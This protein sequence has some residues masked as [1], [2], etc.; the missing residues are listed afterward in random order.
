MIKAVIFDLDDTLY[1]ER[2]FFYGGFYVVSLDL[3]ARGIGSSEE[4]FKTLKYIYLYEGRDKVF[5]KAAIY[6]GFSEELVP[7]LVNVFRTHEPKISLYSDAIELLDYLNSNNYKSGCITDGFSYV[8]RTKISAL[9]LEKLINTII[10]CDDWGRHFWKPNPEPFRLCCKLLGIH[11]TE[12]IF[13]GDNP[14]RDIC[15]ARAAGITSVRI[16]RQSGY[17][18]KS[19]TVPSRKPDFEITSLLEIPNILKELDKGV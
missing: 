17:F 16:I 10:I 18:N 6:L 11:S 13:I 4:I 8:Q 3:E 7:E 5:N 9:G 14:D 15:G 19:N 2:D 1:F 12:A